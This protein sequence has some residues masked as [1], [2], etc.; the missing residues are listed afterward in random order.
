MDKVKLIFFDVETNGLKGSSV[1]SISA[2]KI[3]Y[4][5]TTNEMFKMGEY[6]R[7]YY[8]NEGEE[9]NYG[10]I[11]VNGLN[12]EE[13]AIRRSKSDINYAR[14]FKEDIQSFVDFCD[15]ARHFIAHNIKFD[16]S[17]IPFIL[18][19]QFDTMIENIDIV[20]IPSENYLGY[21][22]PKLNEC[23][24]HYNVPLDYYELHQSI[25]YFIIIVRVFYKMTKNEITKKR[26]LE[27]VCNDVDTKFG[28]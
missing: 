2:M 18:P 19:V 25:Y 15:G 13:I 12:D 8:R 5:P 1:L 14:T 22:W 11:S 24:R 7:F 23:A 4:D 16:R 20:K 9:I 17:F 28:R 26:I 27:F 21:K 10:A 3:L 6:D